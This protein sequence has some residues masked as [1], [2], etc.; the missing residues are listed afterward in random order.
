MLKPRYAGNIVLIGSN[1]LLRDCI[2]VV[3]STGI[4]DHKVQLFSS[5]QEWYLV[6]PLYT[7]VRLLILYEDANMD[8]AKT[9][10]SAR[11][12]DPTLPVLVLSSADD[13]AGVVQAIDLG[14]RGYVSSNLDIAELLAAVRS[15]MS[16]GTFIPAGA[17]AGRRAGKSLTPRQLSI[18]AAIRLGRTNAEIGKELGIRESTVKVHV[19]RILKQ[20]QVRNRTAIAH[21]TKDIVLTGD[22]PLPSLQ[23]ML[24]LP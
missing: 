3:L 20:M 10:A 21:K 1:R 6:S 17:K 16:G 4:P 14:A 8:L 22:F 13:A 12:Y 2:N 24:L 11:D 9:L 5:I 23:D 7:R 19:R 18:I 15:V